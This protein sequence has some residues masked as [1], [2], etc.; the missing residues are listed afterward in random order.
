M[1]DGERAQDG[2]EQGAGVPAAPTLEAEGARIMVGHTTALADLSVRTRGDRVLL[3]GSAE[4]LVA[5]II[6]VPPGPHD[7]DADPPARVVE[8]ALRVGG[9]DVATGQHVAR[10]GV[11]PLQ[12]LLPPKW[13]VQEYLGW[14]ARLGGARKPAAKALARRAVDRLGLGGLRRR[15]LRGLGP[16]DQR[17]VLVAL[18]VVRDPPVIVLDNPLAGLQDEEVTALLRV[19]AAAAEGRAAIIAVPQLTAPSPAAQLARTATDVCLFRGGELVL[20]AEPANLFGAATVYEV[21]VK[22][23]AE[24]LR[25]ALAERG[26]DLRGG[27]EHFSL[28]LPQDRGPSDVLTEAAKVRAAVTSC[29][30][31]L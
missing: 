20:T 1:D 8:G 26:F 6:G 4:A 29:V 23:G 12:P 21:T 27:P 17:A 9:A 18:A 7:H 28:S 2:P 13:T 3:A 11:A 24:E 14:G 16:L 25:K 15:R 10:C 31:L 19:V 22:A 30:P 5:A